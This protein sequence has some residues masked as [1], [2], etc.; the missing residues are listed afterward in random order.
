MNQI[1]SSFKNCEL[2][3]GQNSPSILWSRRTIRVSIISNT[4][5][6]MKYARSPLQLKYCLL[7]LIM[8]LNFT[9]PLTADR[10][11]AGKYKLC[12]K[13]LRAADMYRCC[14]FLQLRTNAT[15]KNF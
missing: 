3:D 15:F 10:P 5:F 12:Q 2:S 13:H 11:C 6:L 8:C 7:N 4:D 1:N 14:V 9:R